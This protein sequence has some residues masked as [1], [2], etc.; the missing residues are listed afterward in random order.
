[1]LAY[2]F[3]RRYYVLFAL[4]RFPGGGGEAKA[5]RASLERDG[6]IHNIGV[7]ECLMLTH[8]VAALYCG[9]DTSVWGQRGWVFLGGRGA[10]TAGAG[11]GVFG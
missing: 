3:L 11:V 9:S 4:V 6:I 2:V 1:M 7:G 5:A 10:F 8:V